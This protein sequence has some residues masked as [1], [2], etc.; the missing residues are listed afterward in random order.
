MQVT[1]SPI[2]PLWPHKTLGKKMNSLDYLSAIWQSK[3]VIHS[4][5]AEVRGILAHLSAAQ[6][7]SS[8][9]QWL[10]HQD[11]FCYALA[12]PTK[13]LLAKDKLISKSRIPHQ[14]RLHGTVRTS[15]EHILLLFVLP[16]LALQPAPIT[17]FLDA[18]P[19]GLLPLALMRASLCSTGG[20]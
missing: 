6:C 20:R 11:S 18:C 7:R 2:S 19:Q 10:W 1:E 9:S 8:S 17:T 12:Q 3:S 15:Y 13:S 14:I 16:R 4:N 5:Q